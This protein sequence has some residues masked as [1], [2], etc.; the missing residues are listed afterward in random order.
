MSSNMLV[1]KISLCRLHAVKL[2]LLWHL[3]S[4]D[5]SIPYRH[6]SWGN[7]S[8]QTLA[9]SQNMPVANPEKRQNSRFYCILRR[10]GSLPI[11]TLRRMLIYASY[12]L[13]LASPSVRLYYISP[14]QEEMHH[15]LGAAVGALPQS[16]Y[17]S[18]SPCR[19]Q[20][21]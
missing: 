13:D 14:C 18:V 2:G 20:G 9:Q 10:D 1:R 21:S 16:I 11:T 4:K 15:R 7:E 12:V 17:P 19:T 6:Y 8:P 3:L 5:L